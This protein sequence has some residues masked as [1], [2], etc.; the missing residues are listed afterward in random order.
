MQ[1]SVIHGVSEKN[2]Y[3]SKL[4]NLH[5]SS[6]VIILHKY[7]NDLICPFYNIFS[8]LFY[9]QNIRFSKR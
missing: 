5:W 1:T 2:W 4:Q 3:I 9:K 7:L 6:D 8:A